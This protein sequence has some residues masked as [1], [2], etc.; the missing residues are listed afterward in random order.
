MNVLFISPNF[1]TF[2]KHFCIRLKENNA[3]VIGLGEAE[4]NSLD[5]DLK[6]ALTEYIKVASLEDYTE[7]SAQFK[8]LLE[9]Y[10]TIDKIESQN[11]YWLSLEAK[12]RSDFNIEGEKPEDILKFKRKSLQKELFLKADIPSARFAVV[13]NKEIL[14]D[15]INKVG[16]PIILKPDIGVG[17]N[18]T[19]LV[20]TS[21]ELSDILDKNDLFTNSYLAEEFIKGN[22]VTFDGI[23]DAKGDIIFKS[24][25][26]IPTA[27]LETVLDNSNVWFYGLKEIDPDIDEYGKKLINLFQ[28][29]SKFFH[30]EFF[31]LLEDKEGLRKKG[32]AVALEVNMRAPGAFIPEMIDYAYDVDIYKIWADMIC[33]STAGPFLDKAKFYCSYASRKEDKVYKNSKDEIIKS[34]KEKIVLETPVADV[35]KKAMGDHV[36]LFRDENLEEIKKIAEFIHS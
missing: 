2:F 31:R 18:D 30:F 14:N 33:F 12:L 9:K 3:T 19:F 1:P 11:E 5:T 28:A 16:F 21:E 25:Q 34:F 26:F 32:E 8:V 7:V 4:E 20:K 22:I 15:F 17:A 27:I 6:E 10:K 29:K 36:F 35:F 23:V 13:D 24:S